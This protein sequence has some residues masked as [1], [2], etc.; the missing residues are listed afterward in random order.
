MLCIMKYHSTNNNH[1]FAFYLSEDK[2]KKQINVS[3]NPNHTKNNNICLNPEI[4]HFYLVRL[5]NNNTLIFDCLTDQ[6][7]DSEACD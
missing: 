1:I 6:C 5:L 3:L 2:H 4:L 7:E